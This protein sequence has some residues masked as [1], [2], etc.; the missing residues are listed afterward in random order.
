MR[1]QIGFVF[2]LLLVVAAIAAPMTGAAVDPGES[3]QTVDVR[4]S[5]PP[6]YQ[7]RVYVSSAIPDAT[8]STPAVRSRAVNAPAAGT[9]TS[10]ADVDWRD[11]GIGAGIMLGTL[12]LGAGFAFAAR[13]TRRA[14]A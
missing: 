7:S 8:P 5:A 13:Q 6:G 4:R 11:A 9:P 2:T 1:K 3:T 14:T 10:S 12:L